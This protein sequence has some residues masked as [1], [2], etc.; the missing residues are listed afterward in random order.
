M[1]I[2]P[3]KNSANHQIKQDKDREAIKNESQSN[4]VTNTREQK[5]R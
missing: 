3:V 5:K 1:N 2:N 4:A